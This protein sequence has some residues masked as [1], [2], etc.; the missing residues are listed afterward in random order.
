[1][2]I[3]LGND[4]NPLFKKL[5]ENIVGSTGIFIFNE[6]VDEGGIVVIV[7]KGQSYEYQD[8]T[9]TLRKNAD[10]PTIKSIK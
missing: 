6:D 5:S 2:V 8:I 10:I 9:E 7:E 1:M 3:I 4:D